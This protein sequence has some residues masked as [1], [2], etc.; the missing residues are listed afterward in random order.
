MTQTNLALAYANLSTGD[1]GTNLNQTITCYEA[2]L[3]VY[4]E[5]DFPVQWATTHQNLA[6]PYAAF[7]AGTV[8]GT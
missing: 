7:Q 3:R 2:A 6:L 1:R 4:T 8:S 5:R